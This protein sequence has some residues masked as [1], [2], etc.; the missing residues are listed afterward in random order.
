MKKILIVADKW[1]K[2]K[3][4]LKHKHIREYVPKTRR[5]SKEELLSMLEQFAM[6]YL[7]PTIGTQG[8]GVMRVEQLSASN[9]TKFRYQSGIQTKSLR[10]YNSL[11]QTINKHKLKPSYLV[12]QGIELLTYKN[13]RFDVRVM[14]QKN[15]KKVWESTG[16]IGRLAHPKKIVTNYHSGGTPLPLE[17]LLQPYLIADQITEYLKILNHLGVEIA[18]SLEKK[19]PG[20]NSIGVDIGIDKNFKPWILEVNTRPDVYIFKELKDKRTFR[21]IYRYAKQ[22]GRITS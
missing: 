8:K 9:N 21:K 15:P 6:V 3:T 19:Y 20:I 7:K 11:Y 12:Q 10:N 18:L 17:T 1:L 5:M 14:V 2:T 4:L 16:I 13:R 22:L